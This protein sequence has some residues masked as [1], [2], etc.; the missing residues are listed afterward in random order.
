MKKTQK[1]KN[2]SSD[3][4]KSTKSKSE[5]ISLIN[6]LAENNSMTL[7]EIEAIL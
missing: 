7:I 2:G 5:E 1:Q 4:T 6:R 3:S